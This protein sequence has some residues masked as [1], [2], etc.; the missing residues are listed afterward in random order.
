MNLRK[1]ISFGM[2]LDILEWVLEHGY[3]VMIAGTFGSVL[4]VDRLHGLGKENE[5]VHG[6]HLASW[7]HPEGG[8]PLKGLEKGRE[9]AEGSCVECRNLKEDFSRSRDSNPS[10]VRS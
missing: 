4:Q 8:N 10:C 2:A 9:K 3:A 7:D 1:A 5:K 6:Q